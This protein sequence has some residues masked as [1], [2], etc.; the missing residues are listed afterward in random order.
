MGK[1]R[2]I[3]KSG[4]TVDAG[5]KSRALARGVRKIEEPKFD[6]SNEYIEVRLTPIEKIP[7]LIQS[8]CITHSLVLVAF[9]YLNLFEQT[10]LVVK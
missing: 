7:E 3:R 4:G 5:L 10:Q 2:I 1:K 8:R 6:R 9:Y